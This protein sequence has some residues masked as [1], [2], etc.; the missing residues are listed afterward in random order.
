MTKS[1]AQV[2]AE[3]S[4]SSF[5][6]AHPSLMVMAEGGLVT[7]LLQLR[8]DGRVFDVWRDAEIG[9]WW[10]AASGRVELAMGAYAWF[11]HVTGSLWVSCKRR[12]PVTAVWVEKVPGKLRRGTPVDTLL[13]AKEIRALR[14]NPVDEDG[15]LVE[16]VRAGTQTLLFS[17]RTG[18]SEVLPLHLL[19]YRHRDY[20]AGLA[21]AI[22][23]HPVIGRVLVN[24]E[25]RMPGDTIMLCRMVEHHLRPG[26]REDD[27]TE[28]EKRVFK[29]TRTC[30][31][32]FLYKHGCPGRCEQNVA[33]YNEQFNLSD[34]I[35]SDDLWYLLNHDQFR[36]TCKLVPVQGVG[37]MV[38]A[39]REILVHEP[40]TWKYN[41]SFWSAES[42]VVDLPRFVTP[43][44]G[45]SIRVEGVAIKATMGDAS[46]SQTSTEIDPFEVRS[47]SEH[48]ET[49]ASRQYRQR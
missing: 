29:K 39:T 17:K 36:P 31:S 48:T 28:F 23:H 33:Y 7:R 21:L 8:E 5:P 41:A 42:E 13:S 45:A 49:S 14:A 26:A 37:L 2:A 27:V 12:R 16:R 25:R 4:N 43:F 9:T 34:P 11:V 1:V 3:V 19:H 32:Y 38:V 47:V 44:D 24:L 6:S 10:P 46:G 40:L 18:R 22:V 20:M 35:K 30:D 15:C